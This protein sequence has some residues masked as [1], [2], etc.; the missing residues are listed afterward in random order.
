MR[1]RS[2]TVAC[3]LSCAVHGGL[4]AWSATTVWSSGTAREPE[5]EFV[6]ELRLSVRPTGERDE[7]P[8]P[9]VA[10][11]P[12][13][14]PEL[15]RADVEPAPAPVEPA[16]DEPRAQELPPEPVLAT[17]EP[18]PVEALPTPDVLETPIPEVVVREPDA[19]GAGA[20]QTPTEAQPT[21]A[22]ATSSSSTSAPAAPSDSNRVG[23]ALA[24]A[25]AG[26]D[27]APSTSSTGSVS[28]TVSSTNAPT[29][30]RAA[31]AL[32]TP[33]PAY[34]RESE[35]RGEHG[36]VLCRLHIGADG[37]VT[38]VELLTSSGFKRLDR[39]ALEALKRWRF[40]PAL[41]AG[42]PVASTLQHK[43]T[44]VFE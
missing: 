27:S 21:L 6:F 13:A 39:A 35:V 29:A 4:L 32:E 24:G 15:A 12:I 40:Q 17:V 30:T 36:E 11:A 9:V 43:V 34:P 16:V 41:E 7:A 8:G 42:K 1:R 37:K 26:K 20:T 14:P 23:R 38:S 31:V 10:A 5:R 28:A 19:S 2:W 22:S 44:F 3:V 33:R 25:V 18:P